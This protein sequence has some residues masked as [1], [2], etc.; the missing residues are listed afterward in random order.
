MMTADNQSYAAAFR[1]VELLAAAANI[2]MRHLHHRY[3]ASTA[4]SLL[5]REAATSLRTARRFDRATTAK[6][7][8]RHKS[9][10]VAR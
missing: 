4:C 1:A 9:Q 7:W 2:D 10:V 5:R 8:R 6:V 3:Q